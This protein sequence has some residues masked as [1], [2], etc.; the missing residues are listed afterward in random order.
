MRRLGEASTGNRAADQRDRGHRGA[1]A[2]AAHPESG[3]SRQV[4]R[5]VVGTDP[6][7]PGAAGMIRHF[8]QF[9]DL[10]G[11]ELMHLFERTRW[12]KQQFKSYQQYWPLTDRTLVM[13]FEKA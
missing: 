11:D 8:L 2:A 10:G 12:I 5:H 3:S 1:P 6:D 7:I 9:K 13:I 4:G